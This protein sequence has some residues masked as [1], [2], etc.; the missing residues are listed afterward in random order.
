MATK[1]FTGGASD[2]NWATSGNW[3]PSGA[4]AN[5]DDVI[6]DFNAATGVN[7]SDQSAVTLNSLTIL[8]SFGS[9]S[10]G[11][12]LFGSNGTPLKILITTGK[13]VRI[14]DPSNSPTPAGGSQRINLDVGTS[15][16]IITVASTATTGVDTGKEVVRIKGVNAAIDVNVLAGSVGIATDNY[17]DAATVNNVNVSG[18]ATVNLGAGV[19]YANLI[20][21]GGQCKVRSAPS[22]ALIAFS[23]DIYTTGTYLV[24]T[25]TI[26]GGAV[27]PQ[28]RAAAGASITMLN[29]R[30]G[31][32]FDT[33]VSGE[34]MTI[35]NFSFRKGSITAF[36]DSQL[37][38]TNN[39]AL[40]FDANNKWSGQ[41]S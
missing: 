12:I 35:T 34:A 13:A 9:S 25:V 22:T 29:L 4:P 27:H 33:S 32:N 23:G 6:F 16:P 21:N 20:N 24:P 28:H 26:D 40:D 15:A 10:P 17:S 31:G 36:S 39:A 38:F 14:G 7:G 41:N 11:L 1:V 3:S 19:T 37:T 2:L 8:A 5:G 18:V 30:G